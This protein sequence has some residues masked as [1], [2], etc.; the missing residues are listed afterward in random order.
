MNGP[1]ARFAMVVGFLVISFW[2]YLV[3]STYLF[4]ERGLNFLRYGQG[5]ATLLAAAIAGFAVVWL[6]LKG[7]ELSV[8]RKKTGFEGTFSDAYG[9][10]FK[11]KNDDGKPVPFALSLSKFLPL[12]V[13]PPTHWPGLHPLEAEL[14]G[15]L[16]G[17]RHWPYDLTRQDISLHAHAMQLWEA[18]RKME[19]S[20]WVHRVAA[21]AQ[22]IGKTYAY[23][24]SR[25]V[26][27]LRQ[28]WK[29]DR[30]RF[31]RRGTEHGG[32][33][34]VI[35]ATMPSF[36]L[37][38]DD[39]EEN[40]RL[41]RVLLTALKHRHDPLSLPT[42]AD[43]LARQVIDSLH[44]AMAEVRKTRGEQAPLRP[45]EEVRKDLIRQLKGYLPGL[46][47]EVT[48]GEDPTDK[49]V[50]AVR[51]NDTVV[52]IRQR[53]LLGRVAQLL[54]PAQRENLHLWESG[55]GVDHP[56]WPVI[57]EILQEIGVLQGAWE[58]V[59]AYH[60][61]VQMVFGETVWEH[62]CVLQFDPELYSGTV[63]RMQETQALKDGAFA[64][65]D[66]RQL[67]AAVQQKA[68]LLEAE[69]QSILGL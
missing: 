51:L 19:G 55:G 44:R 45:D 8:T 27:P 9:T 12:M 5:V 29:R 37:L 11:M 30:V 13:A 63:Q 41:R 28:W 33:A 48:L 36:R 34:G 16:N 23:R 39:P 25:E 58:G 6:A 57:A 21:L 22:D 40:R 53:F 65:A 20:T 7:I 50:E 61:A 62:A 1:K 31:D 38:S 59:P 24:E 56:A 67:A 4:G 32:I 54:T 46:L 43:P 18:V 69:S 10:V 66:K 60:G 64:L 15:F 52:V 14:M 42:N 35:L 2:L 49:N 3:V 68:A 47:D 17:Y 26:Y